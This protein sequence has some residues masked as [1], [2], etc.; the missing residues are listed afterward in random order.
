M[1]LNKK[2]R[3]AAAGVVSLALVAGATAAA[4]AATAATQTNGSA[5]PMYMYDTDAIQ[6]S[7]GY[8]WGWKE[9]LFGSSTQGDINGE[10][11][12]PANSTNIFAFLATPG[13]EKTVLTWKAYAPLAFNGA[14]RNVLNPTLAPISLINNSQTA[15]RNAGGNYS[16]GIA[17]TMNSGVTVTAAFFRTISV[18]PVTGAFT[19]LPQADVP[20]TPTPTPTPT[21]TVTPTP[22]AVPAVTPGLNSGSSGNSVP[23]SS[24]RVAAATKADGNLASTGTA[25]TLPLLASG[26]LALAAGAGVIIARRFRRADK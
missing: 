16:L 11:T 25:N 23:G 1:K 13:T 19:F 18:V 7:D 15:A 3:L 26:M 10:F 20:V 6:K 9:D 2:T 5:A 24:E 14:T 17:C 21:P 8:V 12:C 22:T 4:T